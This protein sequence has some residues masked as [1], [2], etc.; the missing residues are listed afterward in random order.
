V[1]VFSEE[2][3]SRAAPRLH[4]AAAG[5]GS[6]AASAAAAGAAG[7]SRAGGNHGAA[8]LASAAG[9]V[10]GSECGSRAAAGA[11]AN[12]S[13]AVVPAVG[14]GIH[15]WPGSS[16]GGGA[17]GGVGNKREGGSDARS[18]ADE[19]ASTAMTA[20][21][22]I[23]PAQAGPAMAA[24]GPAIHANAGPATA[25][26]GQ[27]VNPVQPGSAMAAPGPAAVPAHQ[28]GLADPAE[29][30]TDGHLRRRPDPTG[31]RQAG[32]LSGPVLG[33][34][35]SSPVKHGGNVKGAEFTRNFIVTTYPV[36]CFCFTFSYV[37]CAL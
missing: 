27:A 10:V 20:A 18:A 24:P 3:P 8:T 11:G 15:A 22:R 5:V 6:A 19:D 25:G 37:H 7:V 36:S 14:L 26:T 12:R 1:R 9:G 4:A 31:G 30:A 28:A 21:G 2:Y 32:Q 33:P 35:S 16:S 23:G 29:P 17:A 34:A 13:A